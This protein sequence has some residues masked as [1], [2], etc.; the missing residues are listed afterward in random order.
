[1]YYI[2]AGILAA[3]NKKYAQVAMEQYGLTAEQLAQVN[4]KTFFVDSSIPV[5]LGNMVGGMIFVGTALYV[6]YRKK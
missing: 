4:W 2:P 1:M 3:G 6:I 5:T